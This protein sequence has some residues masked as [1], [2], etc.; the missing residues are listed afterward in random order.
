[1]G[2]VAYKGVGA[3]SAEHRDSFYLL[4]KLKQVIFCFLLIYL[5]ADTTPVHSDKQHA[6]TTCLTL[7]PCAQASHC[8]ADFLL[9]SLLY[10][11]TAQCVNS[12]FTLYLIVIVRYN[13]FL[14]T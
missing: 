3:H 6:T 9:Y 7:L 8:G 5:I 2:V 1:M 12:L 14:I 4:I 11:P 13:M 10:I